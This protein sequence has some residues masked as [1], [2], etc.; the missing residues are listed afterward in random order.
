MKKIISVLLSAILLISSLSLCAVAYVEEDESKQLLDAAWEKVFG[1][2]AG[3]A[4]G[5][6]VFSAS[7]ARST[8]LY[9]AGLL[10][11]G[12]SIEKADMD[13]DGRITALDARALLRLSAR[14]DPIDKLYT[15]SE[16]K[17]ELFNA[18]ANDVK[19]S[20]YKFRRAAVGTTVAVTNDNQ[21]AITEF[22]KQVNKFITDDADK[23]DLGAMLSE[24]A[25]SQSYSCS[26]QLITAA[27]TNYPVPDQDFVSMLS[28][29]DIKSVVYTTGET[30]NY[31]PK[32]TI[33]STV[34]TYTPVVTLT[35]LDAITVYL[36]NEMV[37]TIPQD[38][39]ELSHGKCFDV[40]Q[41][42]EL[43]DAYSD[44]DDYVAELANSLSEFGS[45]NVF[46]MSASFKYINY[47]DS[48]IKLYF[49]HNTKALIGADYNLTYDFCVNIYMNIYVGLGST[50]LV[51]FLDFRN[52]NIGI[53]DTENLVTT[54]Y[55]E[56]NAEPLLPAE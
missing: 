41:Q 40:P 10:S 3:D 51:E 47:H 54:Y 33:G 16:D 49:D 28:S 13:G 8:L 32:R 19:Y 17:L 34:N 27:D 31:T 30:F 5:D 38:T 43:L 25:G 36:K 48:Y 53:T 29:A 52:K 37:T 9:S 4:N 44:L 12:F 42:D 20:S 15:N 14:L 26:T 22:N 18:M 1:S 2:V 21:A 7:D 50:G 11:E 39:T 45:D 56:K 23:M 24:S 35:G 46:D 55:F 6:G